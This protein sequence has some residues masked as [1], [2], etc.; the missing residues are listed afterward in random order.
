MNKIIT[1]SR[2]YG[3]GGHSIGQR[4]A[5]ELGIP[6]YDKDILRATIKATGYEAD[7][8]EKEQE[9]LSVGENILKTLSSFSI[10]SF[11]DTQDAIFEI[12]RAVI[13]NYAKQGPCVILGRCAD[14][15]LSEAGFDTLNVFVHA[16]EVHR[17]VRLSDSD[18]MNTKN[19]TEIKKMIVKKDNSRHTYYHHYTGKTWGDSHNYDLTVDSGKLGYDLCVKLIVE[20]AQDAV[21]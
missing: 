18:M 13:L 7:I 3:A 1:I 5:A 10:N 19:A 2:E 12:Q 6:F 4:V 21:E 16:D 20:A 17:A 14:V 15:I 11:N 8:V 9:D